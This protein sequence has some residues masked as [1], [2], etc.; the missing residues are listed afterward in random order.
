MSQRE[1]K[2]PLLNA[3]GKPY[4]ENY[5]PHYKLRH[6]PRT[7]HLRHPYPS[8]MKFVGDG[9]V[10]IN[11]RGPP[12][13]VPLLDGQEACD[14]FARR[15]NQLKS[16]R[17]VEKTLQE[18]RLMGATGSRGHSARDRKASSRVATS[19][20][21]GSPYGVGAEMKVGAEQLKH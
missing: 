21:Q 20:D 6:K 19:D 1:N 5:D 2:R 9:S 14:A 12:A 7:G 11:G 15:N 4:G 3:V 8:T 13:P 18:L 10:K 17:E 16:L